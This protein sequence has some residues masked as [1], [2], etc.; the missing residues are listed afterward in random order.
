MVDNLYAAT[1]D[2]AGGG[3][4]AAEPS[5]IQ[6]LMPF[7]IIIVM[8]YFIIYLPNKKERKKHEEMINSIK[9]GD[10]IVTSGGI[11]GIVDKVNENEETIRIKSGESTTLNIKKTFISTKIVK[12]SAEPEKK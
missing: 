3:G 9:P 11:V 10:K 6:F 8:F 2:A 1:A 4:A 12:E 5:M 7:I